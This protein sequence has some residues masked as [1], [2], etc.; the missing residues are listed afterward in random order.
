MFGLL[1]VPIF[2]TEERTP[3]LSRM[4]LRR[5]SL[6]RLR[7]SPSF[8]IHHKANAAIRLFEKHQIQPILQSVEL[9]LVHLHHIVKH[10]LQNKSPL[11]LIILKQSFSLYANLFIFPVCKVIPDHFDSLYI[12]YGYAYQYYRRVETDG[13]R[14]KNILFL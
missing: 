3:S 6:H 9:I 10:R 11:K 12:N 1:S 14:R 8:S 2:Y 7:M 4:H 13:I 5:Y